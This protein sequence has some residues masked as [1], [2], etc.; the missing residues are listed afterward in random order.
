[1]DGTEN[2]KSKKSFLSEYLIRNF[3]HFFTSYLTDERHLR[4][5]QNK[6]ILKKR[7]FGHLESQ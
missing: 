4:Q 2:N 5:F 6:F 3:D 1:M 7:M